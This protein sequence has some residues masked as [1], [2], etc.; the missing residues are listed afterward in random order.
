MSTFFLINWHLLNLPS[1]WMEWLR[2]SL[3]VIIGLWIH[4]TTTTTT[5]LLV[6]GSSKVTL[7]LW[8]LLL[9][10]RSLVSTWVHVGATTTKVSTACKLETNHTWITISYPSKSKSVSYP[11]KSKSKCCNIM[12]KAWHLIHT[13]NFDSHF[14][15]CYHWAISYPKYMAP[16]NFYPLKPCLGAI[17]R[18]I[19]TLFVFPGIFPNSIKYFLKRNH[20]YFLSLLLKLPFGVHLWLTQWFVTDIRDRTY[21]Q[22]KVLNPINTQDKKSLQKNAR[23]IY[24]YLIYYFKNCS[25]GHFTFPLCSQVSSIFFLIF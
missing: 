17:Q 15:S 16:M 19:T 22:W 23:F 7:L 5:I 9:V 14:Q 6:R 2:A 25:L 20:D 13:A 18:Y 24:Y 12:I 1:V 10:W 8:G 4:V 3:P 21:I 11:S